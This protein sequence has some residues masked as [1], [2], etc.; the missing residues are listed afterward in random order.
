[1]V[2]NTKRPPFDDS[3]ARRAVAY[4]LDRRRLVDVFGGTDLAAPACQLLPPNFPGYQ[5]YCPYT[6]RR[7]GGGAW[8]A[9][10]LERARDL[11]AESGTAGIRVDVAGT[12]GQ[13]PFS[14][15]T[16]TL[17]QTLQRLG[18]RAAV[19]RQPPD[20]YFSDSGWPSTGARRFE[21]AVAGWFTDYP[22]PSD[23]MIG[24]LTCSAGNVVG[25]F[26]DPALDRNLRETAQL[27]SR[28]PRAA[29]E[30]WARLEREVIDR[31]IIV[32]VI[33]PNAT[34]FVSKRVGNYQRHPVFGMLISQVWVR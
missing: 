22:A 4:A 31:A 34:D 12:S 16:T 1:V 15:F 2:L 24:I 29:N 10:D 33:T 30:V 13:V 17:V 25:Y 7:T 28:D 8:T 3:R 21:A 18:Y 27:Q 6:V 26:C 14:A 5:R 23:F 20:V 32:P 19:R 11:V 9:P